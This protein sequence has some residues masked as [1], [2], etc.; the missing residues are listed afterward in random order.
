MLI[1]LGFGL[2]LM[3]TKGFIFLCHS[4]VV[5]S[6]LDYGASLCAPSQKVCLLKVFQLKFAIITLLS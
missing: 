3:Y 1:C 4:Y 5:V 2:G 6:L